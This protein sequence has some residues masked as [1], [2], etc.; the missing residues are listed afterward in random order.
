MRHYTLDSASI[1]AEY[2]VMVPGDAEDMP[3]FEVTGVADLV[4]PCLKG[5]KA[6]G[7]ATITINAGEMSLPN[8]VADVAYFCGI[9][10]RG[11]IGNKHSTDATLVRP[12]LPPPRVCLNPSSR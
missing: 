1:H 2:Y 5:D 12:P 3:R 7:N 4:Y 10:A 8:L 6:A 11:V 9:E